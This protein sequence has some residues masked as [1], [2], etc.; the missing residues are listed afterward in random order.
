MAAYG[1][2]KLVRLF[3]HFGKVFQLFL[4]LYLVVMHGKSLLD[5]FL[6]LSYVL[7]VACGEASLD[8]FCSFIFL[9]L[10]QVLGIT[11]HRPS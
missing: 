8:S 7:F 2:V 4:D 1:V 10:T 3:R 11:I 5:A 6:G 9:A